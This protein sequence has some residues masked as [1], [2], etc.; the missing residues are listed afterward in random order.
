[1]DMNNL[2][3][4]DS[5]NIMLI[6]RGRNNRLDKYCMMMSMGFVGRFQLGKTLQ[7]NFQQDN[8]ILQHKSYSS[9]LMLQILWDRKILDHKCLR[10]LTAQL[11]YSN[12]LLYK[13]SMLLYL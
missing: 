7:S 13:V 11:S 1:M 12:N 10:A 3:G 4:K 6:L 2:L 8:I 5:S 9:V